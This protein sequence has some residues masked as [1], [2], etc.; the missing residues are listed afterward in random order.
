LWNPLDYLRLLYWVFYFPQALRWYVDTFGGGDIPRWEMNWRKRWELLRQSAI[1]RQLLLQGLIL[2]VIIPLALCRLLEQR[3][4]DIDWGGVAGG[5]TFGVAAGLMAGLV[6]GVAAGLAAGLAGSLMA[7]LVAG[8]AGSLMAG[9][10]GSLMA[11]LVFGVAGGVMGAVVGG[12]P[13]GLAFGVTADLTLGAALG[14]AGGLALSAVLDMARGV[15]LGVALG[16]AM[17]RPENWLIGLPLNLRSLQNGSWLLPRITPLPLP[18][19]AFRLQNWLQQDWET[20]LHNTNQLL[21][22][23]LQFIPVVKAVNKVLAKTPLEEMIWRV[24]RL[25]E[26]PFD[27]QLVYFTSAS[28]SETLKSRAVKPFFWLAPRWQQHL[29]ARFVTDLRLDTPARAAAAGFWHLHE[30]EP[31]KAINAFAIVRSLLYGEEMFVLAQTLAT[32]HYAEYPATIATLKVPAFQQEPLLRP[33]TWKVIASLHQI[34]EYVQIFQSSVSSSARAR[35]FS[36]ALRQ[37]KDILNNAKTLPQAERGLIVDIAQTWQE[38]LQGIAGEVGEISITKPVINPY[39]V[40]D[41]IQGNLFVGREDVVRQ[42]EELWVMGHHLQS[43]V[44]YGHRR[45]GKTSILLNARHRLGTEVKVAYINLLL[46]GNSAQ[47]VGEVLMA[48]SDAISEAVGCTPPADAD[49]LNL[50]YRTFERYLKQVEAQLNGGL[51]VALDE[52]EKIEELIEAE[53]IPKDFMGYLRGLVQMSSKVAFAFAGLHTLEEMTADYFQPFFA[54]VIPIHVGFLQP[55][56]TRQ[57]LANPD[58][59]FPLDYTPE[60]LDQIYALTAG[61]PY[62]VQLVGFQLVRRY[63]DYVFEQ[64]RPR[65][66]VFTVEDVEAV[67]NDPE[68]FKRGRYYFH[69]VW[70]QAARGA[71]GQQGILKALAPYPDGLSIDALAQVT[72]MEEETLQEALKTLTRHDVVREREGC[73]QI[74]VELFRRWVL[75]S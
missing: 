48:I 73:W 69:G 37:L 38:A 64:G 63:N 7:G 8:V 75:Q 15:A 28:L 10:T 61:Q 53:K 72:G 16:V 29:Q 50:P 74:I 42:L 60:A 4:F 54:S 70:G 41:P 32:F 49:L 51:I 47:G 67:I 71:F 2:T 36:R 58:E 9:V 27:W 3:G 40:G 33:A 62:L 22:Y 17:L 68:F 25:A 30:K 11:G 45:M 35:A 46:L 34:V 59:E 43:V 52:F 13:G 24:S 65:D 55:G 12:V 1:Q 19:L 66:P 5:L 39:I 57:I 23:T 14:V 56:A 31:A 26:A 20:S 18:Y 6:A 21:S 44:L